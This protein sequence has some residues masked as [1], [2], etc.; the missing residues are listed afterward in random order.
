MLYVN[1]GA[2]S[3]AGR[4]GAVN[5]QSNPLSLGTAMNGDFDYIA[6][7]P[8]CY[9][10]DVQM[11]DGPLT[12]SQAALLMANPGKTLAELL[13]FSIQSFVYNPASGDTTLV[14][15]TA[16]N[17]GYTIQASTNLIGSWTSVSN[18]TATGTLT[19]NVLSKAILDAALGGTHRD[20]LFIRVS[21]P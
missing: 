9:L 12:A 2:D 8:G 3:S 16:V 15:G 7:G 17:Q 20:N 10:D 4:P 21:K 13:P 18:L 5:S 6:F 19:T 11:Y 1:G 14:Y